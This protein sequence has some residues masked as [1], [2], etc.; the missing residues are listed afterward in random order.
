MTPREPLKPLD[1][2]PLGIKVDVKIDTT[3]IN[4]IEG[5]IQRLEEKRRAAQTQAERD[6]L[7]E[8]IK[9]KQKELDVANNVVKEE[10]NL[11]KNLTRT[12]E[13]LNNRELRTVSEC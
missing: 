10:E 13:G 8:K 4:A 3:S 11:Y 7:Q 1:L 2:K 5:Q 6:I 12:I 9:I